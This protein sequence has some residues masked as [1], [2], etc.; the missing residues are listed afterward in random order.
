MT[1]LR[2]FCRVV[3]EGSFSAAARALRVSN[4][5][6]SKNIAELEAALGTQLI[7][8]TTRSL[9]LTDAGAEFH[10]RVGH[11]LDGLEQAK[12]IATGRSDHV[13]GVLR[14]ALPMSFGIEA[15]VPLLGPFRAAHPD[16]RLKLTFDD[17]KADII[18]GRFDV[19][20]RGAGHLPDSTLRAR[21]LLEFDRVL[22][23][24]PGYLAVRGAPRSAGEIREHDCIAYAMGEETDAWLAEGPDGAVPI[25]FEPAVEMNNSLAIRRAVLDGLGIA[26]LPVPYVHE[27]LHSGALVRVLPDYRLR[28]QSLSAIYPAARH[29]PPKTRLFID[30]L[31]GALAGTGALGSISNPE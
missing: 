22:C 21:R 5:S 6:V 13:S 20:I 8:R 28:P 27:P 7:I 26:A 18:G 15:I 30:Y 31:A 23:A 24:A 11:V 4:A 12:S 29:L 25:A 16:L 3:E 19:A 9:Q 1:A 2:I 14:V 10:A 17:A